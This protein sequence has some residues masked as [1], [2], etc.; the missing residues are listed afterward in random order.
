MVYC[1]EQKRRVSVIGEGTL[2][3]VL[4][5]M[6]LLHSLVEQR[7]VVEGLK[8]YIGESSLTGISGGTGVTDGPVLVGLF[9]FLPRL[10]FFSGSTKS[11]PG[12]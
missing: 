4:E 9:L 8:T 3:V 1:G 7:M 2:T 10:L 11:A 5:Q 12:I 6:G